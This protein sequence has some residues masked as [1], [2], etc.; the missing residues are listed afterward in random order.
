[1]ASKIIYL[2]FI[3]AAVSAVIADD[4]TC[5]PPSDLEAS[6]LWE[7]F[8]KLSSDRS[9]SDTEDKNLLAVLP[10]EL[11]PLLDCNCLEKNRRKRKVLPEV[12]DEVPDT[13]ETAETPQ[14]PET[15]VSDSEDE[16]LLIG[17]RS[18]KCPQ[19]YVWFGILCVDETLVL[20]K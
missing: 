14:I 12:T 6:G 19:G 20:E 13:P 5:D 4:C 9:E 15:Q 18:P 3:A 10:G 17:V 1:M 11:S 16:S 2:A 8:K 7:F